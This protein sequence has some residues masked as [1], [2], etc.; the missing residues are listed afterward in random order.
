MQTFAVIGAGYGDEGKGRTVNDLLEGVDPRTA[1]VVRHNSSAQA[2]HTVVHGGRRHVFSHFGSGTLR[3]V[4]TYLGSKFILHPLEFIHEYHELEGLGICPEMWCDLSC[5]VT[6]PYDT[7]ANQLLETLRGTERHGSCGVGFGQTIERAL[8]DYKTVINAADIIRGDHYNKIGLV[9]AYYTE[10]FGDFMPTD[11]ID[12]KLWFR[13]IDVLRGIL[14][15]GR[16]IDVFKKETVIFEGAQGLLLDQNNHAAFP[17]VT[18]CSTGLP[19]ILDEATRLQRDEGIHVH[20]VMRPYMTRHGAGP[21]ANEVYSPP[22]EKFEDLTNKP[23]QWQGNLRFGLMNPDAMISTI[24]KDLLVA[25]FRMRDVTSEVVMTCVDQLGPSEVVE[26]SS[27]GAFRRTS[28][29]TLVGYIA[30]SVGAKR[31]VL[32]RDPSLRA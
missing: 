6:T 8:D 23:N 10:R 12:V 4:P 26:I 5:S 3:G 13:A 7:A 28:A 25:R 15:H 27:R 18:R 19:D 30:D 17:H 22:V 1:L 2:G 21:L 32:T 29:S 31:S 9:K 20:Y 24:Q 11:K 14:L 16:A